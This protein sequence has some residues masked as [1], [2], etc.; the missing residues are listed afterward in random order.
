MHAEVITYLLTP[1]TLSPEVKQGNKYPVF[2]PPKAGEKFPDL[3]LKDTN[4][5]DV[6]LSNFE[7]KV[8]L[9]E[10]IAMD[11]PACNAFCGANKSEIKGAFS[12]A[13]AQK[14]LPAIDDYLQG[15]GIDIKNPN[16]VK[17]DL[18]L[19]N[20]KNQAPTP[21]EARE[22]CKHFN[23]VENAHHVVLIGDK[24]MIGHDSFDLIPGFQLLD[25]K[26]VLCS[27]SVGHNPKDDL[28]TVLVPKL[29]LML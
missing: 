13:S 16:Y 21:E 18:I 17:V 26:L 29:K 10:E 1:T 27:D 11:C 15:A 14:G 23:I 19:F 2:W 20:I 3:C 4:G 8:V 9:I 7:G 12:G 6:H 28:W 5:K 25:Q 24:S 22:W